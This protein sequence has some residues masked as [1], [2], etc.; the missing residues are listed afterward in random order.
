MASMFANSRTIVSAQSEVHEHLA[1]RVARHL[2]E[3]FRKPI[4]EPSRRELGA[5]LQ[6]W[7]QAGSAPLILD[8]GCGVGESTLRLATQFPDHFVIGVDQS[9]KRLAAG[10]DWWGEAPMPGNFCW[11]R[12]DLVD[13]W[14]ML[15]ADAVPVA[16]H[17]VLYPNPWPKI[18]HLGRRWQGHAVFPA[19]AACGD[20]LEC[21]SNWRIYIDEFAQALELVGR[22]A[23]VEAWAPAQPMTPFERKYAAS[24]H[25][26]WR[27]VS[28]RRPG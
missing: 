3:P 5:A 25:G 28:E 26:L 2:A 1:A 10:K 6:R 12:A 20:Y 19:L 17:Y 21:R 11:A 24:G 7:Q 13:V 23:R 18:G 4:G 16:R 14:R 27:C 9:E 22:P 15:Q 8:A